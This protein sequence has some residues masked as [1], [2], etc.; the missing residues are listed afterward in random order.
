MTR[1][2]RTQQDSEDKEGSFPK[3]TNEI[4]T[5][6]DQAPTKVKVPID[7]NL[8][9]RKKGEKELLTPPQVNILFLQR[10]KDKSEDR[11]FARF[12]QMLKNG[13]Y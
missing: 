1:S 5:K 4:L 7:R 11:Q 13:T 8:V 9:A 3:A 12:V 6:K 2:K 10:L